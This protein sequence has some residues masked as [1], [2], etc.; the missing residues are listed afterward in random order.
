MLIRLFQVYLSGQLRNQ[1]VTPSKPTTVD[2]KPTPA[3]LAQS[4]STLTHAE[5]HSYH[6]TTFARLNR[7]TSED[8]IHQFSDHSP[9]LQEGKPAIVHSLRPSTR[10]VKRGRYEEEDV[11]E[12]VPLVTRATRRRKL[13]VERPVVA[14]SG[15][16]KSTA[17]RGGGRVAQID[18][19][20]NGTVKHKGG[21]RGKLYR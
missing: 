10:N 2:L 21:Q 18:G 19:T 15:F 7:S 14:V 4:Q 12:D 3:E 20:V 6:R 17:T 13:S 11:G 5:I 9:G 8:D 1:F 16:K